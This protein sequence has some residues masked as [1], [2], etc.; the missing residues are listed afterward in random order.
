[1]NGDLLV[2]K[3]FPLHRVPSAQ[4]VAIPVSGGGLQGFRPRRIFFSHFPA[5]VDED[6]NEPGSPESEGA[7]QCQLIHAGCSA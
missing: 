2:F 6:L 4:I 3:V 1:M 7:R 5:G